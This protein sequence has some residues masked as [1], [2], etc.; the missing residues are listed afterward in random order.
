MT[1]KGAFLLLWCRN[2]F[3]LRNVRRT[4]GGR[5]AMPLK[6]LSSSLSPQ[7]NKTRSY[8]IFHLSQTM[9][10]TVCL[11][12]GLLFVTSL[13][14]SYLDALFVLQEAAHVLAPKFK[15]ESW[16]TW[17]YFSAFWIISL[18]TFSS[19]FLF[20]FECIWAVGS[21]TKGRTERRSSQLLLWQ[22]IKRAVQ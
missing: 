18:R 4:S 15:V 7:H 1:K 10:A 16:L 21:L 22:T 6:L 14:F 17:M 8:A 13:F 20:Y 3:I 5:T 11:E 12:E 2:H 19:L 9:A